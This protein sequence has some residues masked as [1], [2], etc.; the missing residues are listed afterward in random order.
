M[1][2]NKFFCR[3]NS[4]YTTAVYTE[5]CIEGSFL[6]FVFT[7]HAFYNVYAG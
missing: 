5:A 1:V 6:A 3:P 7:V 4:F 2:S